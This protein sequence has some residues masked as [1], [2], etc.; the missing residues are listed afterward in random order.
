MVDT[1]NGQRADSDGT[2]LETDES[3]GFSG[4]KER[5]FGVKNDCNFAI[6]LHIM[7]LFIIF[8]PDF[9]EIMRK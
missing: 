5:L 9:K 3:G 7:A 1:W 4:E 6:D 2:S 8:A